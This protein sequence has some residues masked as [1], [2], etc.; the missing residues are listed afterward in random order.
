[1]DST[2]PDD[3]GDLDGL[4]DV[5]LV[6]EE[7]QDAVEH[8]ADDVL[9]GQTD[10]DAGNSGRSQQRGEIDAHGGQELHGHNCGDDGQRR[11]RA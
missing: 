1:M 4:T 2:T 10:G 7:N 11:W 3:A 8:V 5:E 9:R 6:F